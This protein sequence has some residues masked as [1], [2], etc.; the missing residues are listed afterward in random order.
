MWIAATAHRWAAA[1]R[2][3]DG[4]EQGLVLVFEGLWRRAT[5][6]GAFPKE[7]FGRKEKSAAISEFPE[8]MQLAYL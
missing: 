8:R 2:S 6:S 4:S 7:N 1:L 3:G 5:E